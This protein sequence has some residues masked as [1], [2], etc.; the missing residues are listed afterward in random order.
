MLA[1]AEL[2]AVWEKG[3]DRP[4]FERALLLLETVSGESRESLAE[5]TI[6]QR[7]LHLLELREAL[8][9]CALPCLTACPACHEPLELNLD[10][11]DL[12]VAEE[13]HQGQA[14]HTLTIE[15]LTLEYRL[16]NSL[17]LSAA[18]S[19]PDSH[20]A[21]EILLGRC[22][23]TACDGDNEVAYNALQPKVLD[24]LSTA[25]AE[26]D[27]Q[28]HLELALTCPSCE[29]NWS[30]VFD[31]P[32]YLWSEIQNWAVRT[33]REVYL[34]ASAFGWREADILALSSLRRQLY[35]QS[36]GA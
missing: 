15:G 2:L 12:R 33:L 13:T 19:A 1:A 6:G 31:I 5:L 4:M 3:I 8:F 20:N 32:S 18:S 25:M 29:Q 17:D 27:P 35:L 9:G 34:L 36:I 11:D 21:R 7:D 28:S 23:L 22:L 10:S 24:A 14:H 26:A 16:P 30:T